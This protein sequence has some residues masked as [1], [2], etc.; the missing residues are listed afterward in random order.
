V[1]TGTKEI[2]VMHIATPTRLELRPDRLKHAFAAVATS[3][4]V[5]T[6][7]G[8]HGPRGMTASAVCSVSLDPLLVLVCINN[9]SETLREILQN[10]TFAINFLRDDQASLSDAFAA[11]T[12]QPEKFSTVR[13]RVVNGSPVLDDALAW[14]GCDVHQVTPGGNHTIVVGSVTGIEVRPGDPLVRHSG[15]YWRLNTEAV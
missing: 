11:R 14:V 10:R 15:R 3:V 5:V 8:P 9:R 2:D 6:T 13:Y 7:A 1:T 12:T 4:S